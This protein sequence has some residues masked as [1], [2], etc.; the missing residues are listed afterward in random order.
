MSRRSIR[1][2]ALTA[3][4]VTAVLWVLLAGLPWPA[5]AYTSFLLGP[6]PVLLLL[7][8]RLAD[9]LPDEAEREAVYLSS[10]VSV[11]VLAALAMIAARYSSF[12]R[13]ELRLTTLSPTVLLG[14]AIGTIVAG[15]AIMALGRLVRIPDSA[16]VDYLIP[17]TS[18][19]RIAFTGLSVSAGIAEELIYRSFLIHAVASASGSLIVAVVVS[20][21]AFAMA[22]TYQGLFGVARVALLGLVLTLPFLITGSVYP[23]MI[24][25]AA[26]DLIA[27]LVLADWLRTR[28]T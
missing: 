9:R 2:L 21:A 24:A 10:A 3:G 11:W 12:T 17:R 22:H 15:L 14:V 8:A 28:R 20:I 6:L 18:S 25:H 7:Q 1:V 16:L 23:A 27:G 5:R 26:L 13:A 19:E 4:G